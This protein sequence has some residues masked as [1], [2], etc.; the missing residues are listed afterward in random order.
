V[1]NEK[2]A[3]SVIL[4]MFCL[5][6]P[7]TA[8][9]ADKS[10][11]VDPFYIWGTLFVVVFIVGLFYL[12]LWAKRKD[13]EAMEGVK[14]RDPGYNEQ[15]FEDWAKTVFFAIKNAWL[16]RDMEPVR[17]MMNVALYSDF[18][19]KVKKHIREGTFNHL[20]ELSLDGLKVAGAKTDASNE[21]LIVVLRYSAKD[22]TLDAGGRKVS[23][24]T[25][26]K[27]RDER[28]GFMRPLEKTG[29]GPRK[30]D[31]TLMGISEIKDYNDP[32]MALFDS[33]N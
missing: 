30:F 1:K 9:A 5:V 11:S 25:K 27:A 32:P 6:Q 33:G 7:V 17:A 23:G 29:M 2:L 24:S 10:S 13:R 8:A 21:Y 4:A 20:E 12:V 3:A 18:D 16:N 22:Y 19:S 15:E 31:W 26:N 14:A 28:W